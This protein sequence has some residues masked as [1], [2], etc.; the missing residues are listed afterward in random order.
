MINLKDQKEKRKEII[1]ELKELNKESRSYLDKMEQNDG[2]LKAIEG[3]VK[4][5]FRNGKFDRSQFEHY[6][7]ELRDITKKDGL[8]EM[9]KTAVYDENTGEKLDDTKYAVTNLY[10]EYANKWCNK[11]QYDFAN[12]RGVDEELGH[13]QRNVRTMNKLNGKIGTGE[14][15]KII[16]L[17]PEMTYDKKLDIDQIREAWGKNGKPLGRTTALEYLKKLISKEYGKVLLTEKKG[18]KI[19]YY[20]NPKY[21]FMGKGKKNSDYDVKVYFEFLKNI[22]EKVD[23]IEDELAKKMGVKELTHSALATL[24]AIIPYFHYERCYAVKNPTMR[25]TL[26]GETVWEATKRERKEKTSSGLEYLSIV[27]ISK[28]VSKG[29]N[30]RTMILRDLEILERADAIVYTNNTIL[31]NPKLMWSMDDNLNKPNNLYIEHIEE[32]FYR[33]KEAR[34]QKGDKEWSKK[35]IEKAEKNKE[36]ERKRKSKRGI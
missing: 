31:I 8:Y 15:K 25:T 14:R 23:A 21:V 2:A 11:L 16:K 9:P 19:Y 5:F 6:L 20:F 33:E 17:Y 26:E 24:H 3:R 12:R 36:S 28:I 35:F 7:T 29:E 18:R 13:Y 32:I 10:V 22:I 1:E 27:D 34:E 4:G 30:D